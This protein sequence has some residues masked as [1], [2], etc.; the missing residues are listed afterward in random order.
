MAV[1]L[2]IFSR[3]RLSGLVAALGEKVIVHYEGRRGHRY[4]ASVQ[5]ADVGGGVTYCGDSR[6]TAEQETKALLDLI[7]DL[8][9]DAR[10]LWEK[11]DAR[12]FDIGMQAGFHPFSQTLKL[13]S[14]TIRRLALAHAT[15]VVTTYAAVTRV[16]QKKQQGEWFD[17]WHAF[18]GN[19]S[20]S[21]VNWRS[22][23]ILRRAKDKTVRKSLSRT[24]IEVTGAQDLT[25]DQ[26]LD[27]GPERS[28]S[29]RSLEQML[30]AELGP[31]PDSKA[32]KR[33]ARAAR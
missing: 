15:V 20:F 25:P 17:V 18:D 12:V 14:R 7:D 9:A 24:L 11:A 4:Y 5:V 6:P 3:R 10:A 22:F 23:P 19:P 16:E 32:K 26:F 29:R 28:K 1:G 8:P 13:S 30:R 33:K 31:P 21:E 2:D 27:N